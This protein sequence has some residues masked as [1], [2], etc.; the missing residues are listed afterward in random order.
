MERRAQEYVPASAP[1]IVH[2]GLGEHEEALR[3]LEAAYE[4]RD[5]SLV[6]LKVWWAY[7]PLRSDPRFQAI[8]DRMDFP[9]L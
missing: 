7:D 3:W 8:L 4:E 9:E 1:A 2:L 6:W 5:V